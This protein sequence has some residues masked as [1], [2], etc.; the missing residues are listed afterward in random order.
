MQALEEK[1]EKKRLATQAKVDAQKA[2]GTYMTKAEKEKAKIA[3]QRIEA[4]A[5]AGILP[6]AAIAAGKAGPGGAAGAAAA[7][8]PG[9]PSGHV[10]YDSKKKKG[11]SGTQLE[12]ERIQ[13][14]AQERRDEAEA[15]VGVL[16]VLGVWC[17]W[18]VRVITHLFLFKCSMS[19]CANI[20]PPSSF[21][22]TTGQGPGSSGD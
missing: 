4:M 14:E 2:A 18:C 7:A 11:K 3:A 12:E 13:K 19:T 21:T 10:I 20:P 22:R 16:G 17:V 8:P 5:A 9:A 15:K 6:A 1:R